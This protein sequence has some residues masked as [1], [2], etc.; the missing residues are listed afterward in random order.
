MAALALRS[1][2]LCDEVDMVVLTWVSVCDID[3]GILQ[4]KSEQPHTVLTTE[5]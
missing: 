4:T 2:V 3:N 1:L 5:N